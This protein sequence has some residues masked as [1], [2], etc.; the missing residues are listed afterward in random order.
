MHFLVYQEINNFWIVGWTYCDIA[1]LKFD[2]DK[3]TIT[4]ISNQMGEYKL[5]IT[6][7]D[8][9]A[10]ATDDMIKIIVVK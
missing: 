3:M 9:N 2:K 1:W 4:G 10:N 5:R 7:I 8:H 6:A